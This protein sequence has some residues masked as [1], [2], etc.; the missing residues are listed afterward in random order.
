MATNKEFAVLMVGSE[1][2]LKTE[3][4]EMEY[5]KYEPQVV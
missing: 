4:D 2:D 1:H 5:L 3:I